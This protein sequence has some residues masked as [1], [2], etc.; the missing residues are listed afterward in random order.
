M[1]DDLDSYLYGEEAVTNESTAAATP[2]KAK[3]ETSRDNENPDEAKGE[4]DLVVPWWVDWM[5]L[6]SVSDDEDMEDSDED[7]DVNSTV[8]M[9]R[10]DSDC[11]FNRTLKLFS[12]RMA[13]HLPQHR[14]P[15]TRFW[16][17]FQFFL[18]SVILVHN[19]HLIKIQGGARFN[20]NQVNNPSRR[21]DPPT[22]RRVFRF[23]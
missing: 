22:F 15:S 14:K 19:N 1:D 9:C 2:S 5:R 3:D 6:A 8:G 17:T 11:S 4:N 7:D 20:W 16:I 12:T 18:F 13:S 21:M 23:D 10:D